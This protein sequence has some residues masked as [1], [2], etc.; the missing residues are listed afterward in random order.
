MTP[1]DFMKLLADH[2]RLT[3]IVMLRDG[4]R[5]VCDLTD[6]M[7]VSQPKLSRHLAI[8]REAGVVVTEK[9][10]QWVFYSLSPDLPDWTLGLVES[11]CQAMMAVFPDL[12]NPTSEAPSGCC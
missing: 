8:L 2:T 6:V 3:S 9:R 7:D 11:A 10:G 5:C 4:A 12:I 1:A